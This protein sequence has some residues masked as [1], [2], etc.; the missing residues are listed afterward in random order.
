MS[1][2]VLSGWRNQ[3]VLPLVLFV[4]AP[5]NLSAQQT[6]QTSAEK[7]NAA[8][9][10]PSLET[11]IREIREW[12]STWV[13]IRINAHEWNLK[14][15]AE[16]NP[17]ADPDAPD[18][19]QKHSPRWE[20]AWA[21]WGA[22]RVE[23]RTVMNG[24]EHYVTS[25]GTNGE[26]PW[27]SNSAMGDPAILKLVQLYH[28]VQGRPLYSASIVTPIHG[29]WFNQPGRWLDEELENNPP[30]V[31]D[32]PWTV[33]GWEEVDGHRCVRVYSTDG[34]N[35]KTLW[36]DPEFRY[37]PRKRLKL[38]KPKPDDT[39]TKREFADPFTGK[40]EWAYLYTWH[41]TRISRVD[42]VL[43]PS[44]GT[45]DENDWEIDKIT[46]NEPL[47][48]SYFGPPEGQPGVTGFIDY[49]NGKT[50]KT[51]DPNRPSTAHSESDETSSSN[52][53]EENAGPLVEAVPDQPLWNWLGL[54]GVLCLFAGLGVALWRR[55]MATS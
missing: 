6:P 23:I 41:A 10:L 30:T 8:E 22:K 51:P 28:P 27:G 5:L 4:A 21:D 50:W 37:L 17:D 19:I 47:T 43:F 49:P 36:L 25:S 18:Y 38:G 24:K 29:L 26:Q 53:D 1:C 31:M 34:R 33:L 9:A 14:D 12:R 39:T 32:N 54:A 3:L 52:P 48:R 35:S 15:M 40:M 46:V 2:S 11:C 45:F 42:G 13:T 7:K 55:R 44:R 16:C 20:F